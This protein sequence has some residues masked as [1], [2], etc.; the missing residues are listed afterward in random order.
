MIIAAIR[1]FGRN[2]TTFLLAFSLAL[3][4]WVSAVVASD[5][6]QELPLTR[7]IT[8]EKIG[9]DP[10]MLIMGSIPGQVRLTLNAPRSVW[11]KITD[12]SA[13]IRAWIDL[14]GLE[15][16]EHTLPVHIQV[17]P[18]P[19][20]VVQQDPESLTLALEPLITMSMPVNL[21]IE[22]EPALGY[23]AGI[24]VYD[25]KQV[26]ISGASSLV[27]QVEKVEAVMDISNTNQAIETSLPL[28]ALDEKGEAVS[29]VKIIPG[30]IE[31]KE[32]IDLLG[33]YRNVIVKVITTG[34][35]AN[36][37]K[38]TNITVSPPN[39]IVFSN[40]LRLLNSLPGYVETKA[41]DLSGLQDDVETLLE[42][43]LPVGISVVNDQRVVV[44]VSVA[45]IESNMILSLPVEIIGLAPDLQAKIA[46]ATVDVILSGPVPILNTLKPTDIRVVVDVTGV[47]VGSY[48]L[49]PEVDF[50]PPQIKIQSIL[51]A[52]LE[53]TISLAPTPTQTVTPASQPT[54]TPTPNP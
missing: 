37:Y 36:G 50:L 42:L 13:S 54:L 18:S 34:Q 43:S 31:V 12:D 25:P 28:R 14:S 19:V 47:D 41:L 45:A 21:V 38:L 20:I 23:K 26:S 39:V 51:P 16:G 17:T 1:W 27:S 9:Q 24:P 3:V 10:G 32:S 48:Q 7:A 5:P 15:A 40:D 46:P 22:G 30:S 44:Q 33:E 29:G 11:K 53:L 49:A 4:V 35:V 2:L 52:T 6:N 8:I